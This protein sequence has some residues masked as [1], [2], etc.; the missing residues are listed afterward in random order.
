[1]GAEHPDGRDTPFD[2]LIGQIIAERFAVTGPIGA[3]GMG[4]VYRAIQQAVDRPV[5]LKILTQ[6]LSSSPQAVKRFLHEARIISRLKHVNTVTLYDFGAT[7]DG[8]LYIAM[9]LIEGWQ[10]RS[11]IERGPLGVDRTLA[12][13]RQIAASLAEAHALG[14]VHRDLKPE[15]IM[16]QGADEV[17]VVD[18]GIAKLHT[19]H[20]TL[21]QPGTMVGTPAYMSPEHALSGQIDAR[22]DLYAL[23]IIMYE[24][25]TGGPLFE[26]ETPLALLYK[27]VHD[28]PPNP[29]AAQPEVPWALDA[30]VMRLLSKEPDGRP[31]DAGAL[32]A[33]LDGLDLGA[34]DPQAGV[35]GW[36]L[37]P[38]PAG[39]GR[40]ISG[41]DPQSDVADTLV[42]PTP[43]P[44]ALLPEPPEAPT[45]RRG[46]LLTG[47]GAALGLA[48]AIAVA[49][50]GEEP[51]VKMGPTGPDRVPAQAIILDASALA[52][53]TQT[54][55]AATPDA[56][57]PDAAT[58][59]AATP[60][61]AA[62]IAAERVDAPRPRRRRRGRRA[63]ADKAA[64][65]KAAPR[66]IKVERPAAARRVKISGPCGDALDRLVR[67]SA[68]ASLGPGT[69]LCGK[70]LGLRRRSLSGEC[71]FNGD[72]A[73][74]LEMMAVMCRK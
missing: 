39:A 71:V 26:A 53:A 7:G 73:Q 30:L 47:A 2:P 15:N 9:E 50:A 25:L 4:T 16:I 29:Q 46:L 69:P 24:M 74:G 64:A 70:I 8:R 59:D 58:P 11:L 45:A 57:S 38:G 22:A 28:A 27:Q 72:Q 10:L 52:A 49:M 13:T 63:A 60:D 5:A 42:Q 17:R 32:L 40:E 54:P 44:G 19:G 31:A 43:L 65:D 34:E 48:A 21:T 36:P 55:D 35:I 20:G 68:G 51:P 1:M 33:L 67:Q 12:I 6:E 37:T 3:G 18:F 41:D 56:A 14:V 61:A 66:R 23:G 62:E